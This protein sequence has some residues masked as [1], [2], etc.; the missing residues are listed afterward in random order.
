MDRILYVDFL[1]KYVTAGRDGTFRLWNGGDCR[2]FKTLS[3]NSSWI[4]DGIFMPRTRKLVFTSADR[5][6]SYYDA[7]RGSFELTGRISA[8]GEGGG[9]V[10]GACSNT[11]PVC[12]APAC[13]P[14]CLPTCPPACLHPPAAH[15][16]ATAPP[17]Q[18]V[19]FSCALASPVSYWE[20]CT[21][22]PTSPNPLGDL[23]LEYLQLSPTSRW[24]GLDSVWFG[25]TTPSPAFPT[26]FATA[27]APGPPS[28]LPSPPRPSGSMG[29]PQCMTLV[30]ND[31]GEQ[32]VYGD[33]KGAVVM[34]LCGSREWPPRDLI[35]TDEHQVGGLGGL[36]GG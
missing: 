18:P 19:I 29:V 9:E 8:S 26:I 6:I 3:I 14:A 36:G 28:S 17:H 7:N 33:S 1:D 13:L 2:H 20:W 22:A 31:A 11:G 4:T 24:L 27:R 30:T 35:S 32:L 34:L 23:G 21:Q 15:T 16:T 5:A 10:G 25:F 12:G